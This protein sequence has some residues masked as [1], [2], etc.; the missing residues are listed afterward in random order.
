MVNGV[1]EE[2]IKKGL[3]Q[4]TPELEDLSKYLKFMISVTKY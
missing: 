4:K 3:K 2:N 1:N